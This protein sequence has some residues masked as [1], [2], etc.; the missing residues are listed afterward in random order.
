MNWKAS[1]AAAVTLLLWSSAFAGIRYGLEAGYTAGH[2]VLIRFLSA[3]LAF[4]VYALVKRVRI[5]RLRDVPVIAVLSFCGISIYHIALTFGELTVPAGTASLIIATAPAFSA[6]LAAFALRERLNLVGWGGILLGFVGIA[7]IAFGSGTGPAFTRGAL[8]ILLSALGTSVFFVYQKPLFA[9]YSPI[10][11]T[12]WF[13]WFGTIPMLWFLPGLLVQI[14][15][16]PVQATL[17]GVYVGVFPAAIAYGAWAIALSSGRIGLVMSTLYLEPVLAILVAWVWLGEI[18][19]LLSL[20]GG[21][22]AIVGVIVTNVWG[23]GR[24]DDRAAQATEAVLAEAVANMAP[25]DGETIC[26]KG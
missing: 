12:A 16:A 15:H 10:D 24:S 21:L 11:M 9:R 1:I 7:V 5:P 19:R 18:P 25:G 2:V 3:S 23:R 17:V 14:Q 8:L 13:T 26:E 22:I 6:L 4:A 20:L